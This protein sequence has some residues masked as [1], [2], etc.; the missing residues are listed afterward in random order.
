[1][2]LVYRRAHYR[3]KRSRI[4]VDRKQESRNIF[5][6]QTDLRGN[7]SFRN[8]VLE[9]RLEKRQLEFIL[10]RG[11]PHRRIHRRLRFRQPRAGSGINRNGIDV[12]QL[13][14]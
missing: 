3:L 2:A 13:G 12:Q 8:P 14:P 6:S 7:L 5:N 10:R 11:N 9:L 1:M 4:V